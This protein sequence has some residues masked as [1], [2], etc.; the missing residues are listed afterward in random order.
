MRT[1]SGLDN[2]QIWSQSE[3][4]SKANVRVDDLVTVR[5]A[6]LGSYLLVTGV[7]VATRVTREK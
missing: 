5:R 6:V 3:I 4:N 2:A 7:G 1:L